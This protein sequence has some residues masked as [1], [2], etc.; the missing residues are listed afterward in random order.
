MTTRYARVALNVRVRGLFDYRLP[1]DENGSDIIGRRVRVNLRQRDTLG[2]VMETAS[3]S[4]LPDK[5]I[6]PLIQI[7]RDSPPLP[8]AILQLIQFCADYYHC[9]V[10]IAAAAALPSFLRRRSSYRL[11]TGYRIRIGGTPSTVPNG[12]ATAIYTLLQTGEKTTAEI[13]G[14]ID[15]PYSALKKLVSLDLIESC[16]LWRAPAADGDNKATAAAIPTAS[17]EQQQAIDALELNNGFTPH[18]LFG[19]TGSGKSEIYLH[20]AA[21]V[22]AQKKQV[23]FLTPEI[24]LTPQLEYAM[25]Q[26]FPGRSIAVLHSG[27]T[28]GERAYRWLLARHGKAD[29]VL[30]TRLAVFTPLPA[31]G[32]IIIDEEHDN[33]FKQE[34]GGL[35]F[36]ARNVAI[37]RAKN[38]SCP[39]IAG[40]ATPAL[41]SVYNARQPGWRLLTMRERIS[42]TTPQIDIISEGNNLYHGMDSAFIHRL[43]QALQAGRQCL[44]FI[45]RRGYAPALLCRSCCQP[46]R[47]RQCSC[48]MTVHRR[49]DILL[50]H[51]C[52][53]HRPIPT[54]CD[55]CGGAVIIA[56]SGTQRIEEALQRLFP[57]TPMLRLDRDS[58]RSSSN[59][60]A[61]H[62]D[63]ITSGRIPLIIGTQLIA[64]G[65][66]FPR[67][68]F[69][70]ILN[71]DAA[72]AAAD[73][74]A[75]ERLFALL[76]QVIG[77]G[78]R[79]PEGCCALI[80]TR[81]PTHPFYRELIADDVDACWQRLLQERRQSTMPPYSHLALLRG[82][83]KNLPRLEK[84]M[85]QVQQQAQAQAQTCRG[86]Q[87]FDAVPPPLE[88]ISGWERRQILFSARQ[89]PQLQQFLHRLTPLIP[90]TG[91]WLIDVDP[92]S[93]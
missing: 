31:L 53:A 5:K 25:R 38:E 37:W 60:F 52:G 48:N 75:E 13:R 40:S 66:N 78:T 87:V 58:T 34:E 47:C 36:S 84:F 80:Q 29:I 24:H 65:H 82:K 14:K 22:L 4:T 76:A 77:R 19:V 74:R 62:Y 88:K 56:G 12:K 10:G 21:A 57:G 3:T 20:A 67:L 42:Y 72:L 55:Q 32:L 11:P 44:L 41:E 18:L 61:A 23:L 59:P 73:L 86:V 30:G 70:G 49:R 93:V 63:D 69:I 71:A 90:K 39:V 92:I 68:G 81:Y 8:P 27:L 46:Q 91:D 54:A 9:P 1:A 7:Y 28:D 33:S 26:R 85:R 50:C 64:K 43:T 35:L 79:N 2:I 83:D 17:S 15:A 6:K 45:N 16:L 89:R 51:L